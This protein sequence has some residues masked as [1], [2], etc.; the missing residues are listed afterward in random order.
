[1]G[2]L[3]TYLQA[4]RALVTEQPQM[5]A[6]LTGTRETRSSPSAGRGARPSG[7]RWRASTAACS[8][9]PS[10]PPGSGSIAGR[11][12]GSSGPCSSAGSPPRR[13]SNAGRCAG[14]IGRGIYRALGAEDIRHRRDASEE[15]LLRRLLSLD[16]VLEYPG[17]VRG[18]PRNRRRSARSRRSASSA[19][20]CRRASTGERLATRGVTSRSSCRSHW[21]PSAPSS[22]SLTR[23]TRAPRRSAPGEPGTAPSGRR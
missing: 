7:L 22:S 19:A 16:Y 14:S 1:M 12:F 15:V 20:Y 10:S 17:L 6:H 4:D 8:P 21:T 11:P 18:S 5:I 2:I 3:I 13:S 23:V 9:A